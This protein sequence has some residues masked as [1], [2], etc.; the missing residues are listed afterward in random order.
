MKAIYTEKAP[1]P[2]GPY[3]QAIKSNGF[4]FVSGQLGVDT[5]GNVPDTIEGQTE[6]SIKN[7]KE[8]LAK[9]NLTLKNVVKATV[10]LTTMDDFPN[11]N[12]VYE[13]HF[14]GKPARAAV[15]VSLL[16]NFKVEIE[17]IATYE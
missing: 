15:G 3:S 7:I 5:D 6:Q 17:V 4:L 8:I 13:K 11:M 16:K 10:F 9:E 1:Q 14:T 12:S 2:V